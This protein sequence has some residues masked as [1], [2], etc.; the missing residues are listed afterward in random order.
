MKIFGG[1][2]KKDIYNLMGNIHIYSI[3]NR[4]KQI[5]LSRSLFLEESISKFI[6]LENKH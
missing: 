4:F 5:L 1:D 6:C 3:Q 2:Y